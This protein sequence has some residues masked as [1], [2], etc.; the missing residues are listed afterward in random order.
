MYSVLNNI[1]YK[2]PLVKLAH[3]WYSHATSVAHD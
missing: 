3:I 1:V 2:F